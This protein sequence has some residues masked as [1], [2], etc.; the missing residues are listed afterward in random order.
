MAEELKNLIEKIQEEGIKS[1]EEKARAIEEKA[2][3]HA[4]EIINKAKKE[5]R[6]IIAKAKQDA[7]KTESAA[8]VTLDQT[9]RDFL[10]SL[11]KEIGLT[12]DRVTLA[13]I[14][15]A[16]TAHELADVI[17]T[18]IKECA[19]CGENNIT[20]TLNKKDVERVEK[21]LISGVREELKKGMTVRSSEDVI[22][23]FTISFDGGKS[24]YDF[25]DKALAEY[26]GLYV[27]PKLG[28]LLKGAAV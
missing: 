9:A 22:G 8:R 2:L 4:D 13:E 15:G 23:G 1:A 11:R 18:L 12:L 21:A 27:H 17:T 7:D 20:V 24:H 10:I 6:D 19:K 26:I 28:D 3:I 16:L 5:S 25:S 14:Q